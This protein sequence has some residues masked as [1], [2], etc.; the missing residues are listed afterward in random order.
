MTSSDHSTL[1]YRHIPIFGEVV[2]RR[3][4][5]RGIQSADVILSVSSD[6]FDAHMDVVS[7]AKRD[8]GD[9]ITPEET[10]DTGCIKIAFLETRISW[11]PEDCGTQYHDL[12]KTD[13]SALAKIEAPLI[14]EGFHW[15]DVLEAGISELENALCRRSGSGIRASVDLSEF[16]ESGHG[17]IRVMAWMKEQSEEGIRDF[18]WMGDE[19]NHT[20][21]KRNLISFRM[22]RV[23]GHDSQCEEIQ[24]VRTSW[25]GQDL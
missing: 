1:P 17:K 4:E 11:N 22:Q 23:G 8:L 24:M 3:T 10:R 19:T 14:C 9:R 5:T 20:E 2:L 6:N 15:S 7:T 12:N 25:E 18:S 21:D 13:F 16:C